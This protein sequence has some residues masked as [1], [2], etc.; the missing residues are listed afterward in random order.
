MEP[1]HRTGWRTMPVTLCACPVGGRAELE[2]RDSEPVWVEDG[3]AFL[4]NRDVEHRITIHHSGGA[5]SCWCHFRLTAFH[6]VDVM[7]FYDVPSVL[8]GTALTR[9]CRDMAE[10]P[11]DRMLEAVIDQKRL[12]LELAAE[13]LKYSEPREGALGA[14]R[15]MSRIAPAL[16]HMRQNLRRP[17]NLAETAAALHCSKSRFLAVFQEVMGTSPGRHFNSLR[18]DK[19][20]GMLL[21]TDAPV[22]EIAATLG[23]YDAFHFSKQ[24][25]LACGVGPK[26]YRAQRPPGW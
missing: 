11:G 14:L 18:L 25:K 26:E 22:A 3:G 16:A 4:V 2:L 7:S 24:F 5:V 12:G 1:M 13:L 9:L 17:F 8:P 6:G 15:A 21:S 20:K 10:P 23:Y 19:A